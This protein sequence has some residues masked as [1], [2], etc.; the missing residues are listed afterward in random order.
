MG[1]AQADKGTHSATPGFNSL[2]AEG[3]ELMAV[4]NAANEASKYY[5]KRPK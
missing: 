3:W 1:A 2:G 5:F 4:E